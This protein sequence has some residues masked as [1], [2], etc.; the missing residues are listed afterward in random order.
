MKKAA[1]DSYYNN[2]SNNQPRKTT[3][4]AV[5]IL[6][7]SNLPK[8]A[9]DLGFGGGNDCIFLQEHGYNVIAID[10]E[11]I[12]IQNLKKRLKQYDDPTI[13]PVYADISQAAFPAVSLINASFSL[14][15]LNGQQFQKTW[16]YILKSL[17]SGGILACQLFG[18]HDEWSCRNN[19]TFFSESE[20]TC[21]IKHY[22]T[23]MF[24]SFKGESKIADG[25]K[26]Y[27]HLYH[28]VLTKN[29]N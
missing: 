28:L 29:T 15:F 7:K 12:A 17:F 25:S 6:S 16:N 1:W 3:L 27:W 9:I 18:D 22:S 19:M 23:K 2:T 8:T 10:N 26:K 13:T 24:D 21:L 5:E 14:P 4:M 11:P 20:I